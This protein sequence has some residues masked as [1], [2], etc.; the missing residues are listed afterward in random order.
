MKSLMCAFFSPFSA[1]IPYFLSLVSLFSLL[2]PLWSPSILFP[3]SALFLPKALY[4]CFLFAFLVFHII[5]CFLCPS[6]AFV[7]LSSLHTSFLLLLFHSFLNP[8]QTRFFSYFFLLQFLIYLSP[9]SLSSLRNPFWSPYLS[10]FHSIPYENSTRLLLFPS[11][12][13]YVFIFCFLF[14]SA[15]FEARL[16][17]FFFPRSNVFSSLSRFLFS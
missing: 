5:F 7:T 13:A 11:V 1:A 16:T 9:V 17:D 8:S 10:F 4:V 15:T 6:V 3:S 14:P 12:S 2:N